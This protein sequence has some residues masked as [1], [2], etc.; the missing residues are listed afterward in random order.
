[1]STDYKWKASFTL[2]NAVIDDSISFNGME[3]I[4]HPKSDKQSPKVLVN[5]RFTT[6]NAPPNIHLQAKETIEKF[7]DIASVEIV[8]TGWDV[9]EIVEDFDIDLEN[10]LELLKQRINPPAKMTVTMRNTATWTKNS[11]LREWEWSQKLAGH[12][13]GGPIPNPTIAATK[14]PRRGRI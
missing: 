1:M 8:L 12:K 6:A 2:H 10:R 11:T 14:R 7:L 3:I 9:R 5:Y 4:P 13:D